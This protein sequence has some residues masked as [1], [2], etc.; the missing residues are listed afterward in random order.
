MLPAD[1]LPTGVPAP[2]RGLSPSDRRDGGRFAPGN[3]LAS[4]GARARAGSTR[5]AARLSL[6]TLPAD[7]PFAPYQRA[8]ASFRRAQ[9]AALA[10][11]VGGGVCGPG[12]SS[13]VASAALALAWSRYLSDLAARTGDAELAARAS[14]LSVESRQH[15][16][17]AHELCAREAHARP[18]APPSWLRLQAPQPAEA[19]YD[20]GDERLG[21]DEPDAHEGSGGGISSDA[22]G[23]GEHPGIFPSDDD[24][25]SQPVNKDSDVTSDAPARQLVYSEKTPGVSVPLAAPFLPSPMHGGQLRPVHEARAMPV[26]APP[27]DLAEKLQALARSHDLDARRRRGGAG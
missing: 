13:I 20:Q 7:A 24:P 10:S 1:E 3:A 18:P 26:A 4:L 8:A 21:D 2:A 9:S 16:L 14:R 22:G 25:P 15:L 19:E 17:A 11:S 23:G 27:R 5:L 6:A 12:P